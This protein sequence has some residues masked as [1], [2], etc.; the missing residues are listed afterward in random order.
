[1]GEDGPQEM[2]FGVLAGVVCRHVERAERSSGE[3]MVA[4]VVEV[5][6]AG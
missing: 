5:V 2:V 3:E 1:M 4:V 6:G